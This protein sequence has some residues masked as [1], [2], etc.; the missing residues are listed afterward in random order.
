[1]L[2]SNTR[3]CMQFNSKHIQ[4]VRVQTILFTLTYKIFS[5]AN[6]NIHYPHAAEAAGLM[7]DELHLHNIAMWLDLKEV[8]RMAQYLKS[9]LLIFVQYPDTVTV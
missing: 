6:G 1:M 2:H 3:V 8:S 5:S 7:L 4:Y 9:I